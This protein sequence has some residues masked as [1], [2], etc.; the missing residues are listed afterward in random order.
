LL[1]VALLLAAVG[2]GGAADEGQDAASPYL[3]YLP[4]TQPANVLS[5]RVLGLTEDRLVPVEGARVTGWSE[6]ATGADVER[7]PPLAEGVSDRH[8]FV[9]LTWPTEDERPFHWLAEAPGKAV[10]TISGSSGDVFLA[11]G[12]PYA[13]RVLGPMGTPLCDAYVEYYI[14]GC[15]HSP[16]ARVGTTDAEGL[17]VFAGLPV[18][19]EENPDA[20]NEW[21]QFWIVNEGVETRRYYG[22]RREPDGGPAV[23]LTDPGRSVTGTIRAKDGRPRAGITVQR[24]GYPRGPQTATDAEGRFRLSGLATSGDPVAIYDPDDPLPQGPNAVIEDYDS[25]VPV[26]LTLST[27][28]ASALGDGEARHLIEVVCKL[29]FSPLAPTGLWNDIP[30]RLVRLS[31][32]LVV[33]GETGETG[34]GSFQ[35]LLPPGRYRVAAGG[36]VSVAMR[37]T[38]EID[39][40]ARASLLFVLEKAPSLVVRGLTYPDPEWVQLRIPGLSPSAFDGSALEIHL[41]PQAPAVIRVDRGRPV[42][43]PVGAVNDEFRLA[44]V[45]P[46]DP[47][48]VRFQVKSADPD[49]E[50]DDVDVHPEDWGSGA[51]EPEQLEGGGWRWAT[52]DRGTRR[53]DVWCHGFQGRTVEVHLASEARE[54]Q[55][56]TIELQPLRPATLHVGV[57]DGSVPKDLSLDW[58]VA[59][60]KGNAL[61]DSDGVFELQ[62]G[63]DPRP[64][65]LRGSGIYPRPVRLAADG[66]TEVQLPA[67]VLDIRVR[68]EAGEALDAVAYVDHAQVWGTAGDFLLRGVPA[69]VRTVIVGARDH[70]GAVRTV[71]ISE[72][73]TKTLEL[74]LARR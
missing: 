47:T 39:V 72:G 61:A 67:G 40:P 10:R 29:R 6:P 11:R 14:Y 58:G 52:Y 21:G 32:G 34:S 48:V 28:R 43:L 16:A 25:D 60:N 27:G 20:H 3:L 36:G 71:E 5:V 18:E 1:L 70:V 30:V 56:G 49:H 13:L 57:A 51:P 24:H 17:V 22:P 63:P 42:L 31:D 53:L 38:A 55:L 26:R 68:T 12:G 65:I 54:V 35:T 23:I 73:E 37:E 33:S 46:E 69:G 9:N 4:G 62:L 45:P 15:P 64:G 66:P 41:P 44:T 59:G 74:R 7:Y 50:L 2:P 8:G 19:D